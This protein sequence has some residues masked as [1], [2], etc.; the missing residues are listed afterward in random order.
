MKKIIFVFL[1]LL[2]ISFNAA[3]QPAKDSIS[4]DKVEVE[5]SFPGGQKG[6]SDYLS[7]NLR[8]NI[9]VKKKAKAGTY[10]VVVHFIVAKD[11]SIS[12]CR[13]IQ[14]MDMVSKRN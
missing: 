5:A 13:Q 6:W 8:A 2:C 9:P 3:A 11:G 14:N 7:E 1:S 10:V 4:F 12:D